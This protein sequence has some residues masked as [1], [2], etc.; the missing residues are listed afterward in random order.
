MIQF[1]FIDRIGHITGIDG[2][3]EQRCYEAAARLT[4]ILLDRI[5][6]DAAMLVSDHGFAGDDHTDLGVWGL[7]GEIRDRVNLTVGY[8]P[9]LLDIAPTIAGYFGLEHP[10]EGNDLT[11]AGE[12][13]ARS[14]DDDAAEREDMIRRMKDLGYM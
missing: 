1:S 5:E 6:P 11:A 14:N 12:A 7:A 4:K 3:I 8:R 2:E 9:S 13:T 10:C